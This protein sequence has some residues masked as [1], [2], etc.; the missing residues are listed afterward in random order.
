VRSSSGRPVVTKTNPPAVAGT[1]AGGASSV[2]SAQTS[3]S[4]VPFSGLD[5]LVLIAGSAG[6][7][8]AGVVIRR[9]TRPSRLSERAR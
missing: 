1:G 3:A 4:T 8:A 5:V 9:L 2:P 6:L 7:L